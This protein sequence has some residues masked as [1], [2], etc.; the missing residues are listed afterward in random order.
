[1]MKTLTPINPYFKR[2]FA[3]QPE[4]YFPDCFETICFTETLNNIQIFYD[5]YKQYV[6]EEIIYDLFN[7]CIVSKPEVIS[8]L[9]YIGD[10]SDHKIIS[11]FDKYF[12]SIDSTIL[13]WFTNKEYILTDINEKFKLCCKKNQMEHIKILLNINSKPDID[14]TDLISDI[15]DTGN[16]ELLKS[17]M[18]LYSFDNFDKV[19]VSSCNNNVSMVI[20]ILEHISST[21]FTKYKKNMLQ[22]SCGNGH[23]DVMKYLYD[24]VENKKYDNL[25][26]RT[27]LNNRHE[28][29][30]WLLD[31]K[32]DNKAE[33]IAGCYAEYCDEIFEI[34]YD[35]VLLKFGKLVSDINNTLIP[36]YASLNKISKIKYIFDKCNPDEAFELFIKCLKKDATIESCDF[37]LNYSNH[38]FLS[39]YS[40]FNNVYSNKEQMVPG[41]SLNLY[42]WFSEKAP[43]PTVEYIKECCINDRYNMMIEVLS[44]QKI[45]ITDDIIKTCCIHDS[46]ECFTILM[47]NSDH[48]F[49]QALIIACDNNSEKIINNIINNYA[50]DVDILDDLVYDAYIKKKSVLGYLL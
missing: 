18:E 6:N 8:W 39:F 35:K 13:E 17:I 50:I 31:Q 16:I 28:A 49:N 12:C 45:N 48:D 7:K 47:K 11:L 29:M 5:S 37:M 32:P 46:I 33:C 14:V 4:K 9:T 41:L 24:Q 23:L 3:K 26:H 40:N 1:M 15:C 21:L 43:K 44:S 10:F 2:L 20:F 34:F 36:F 25:L 30:Q 27:C 42:K 22:R 38:M 19:R